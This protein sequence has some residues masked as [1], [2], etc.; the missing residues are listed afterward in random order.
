MTVMKNSFTKA[1]ALMVLLFSLSSWVSAGP[2]KIPSLRGGC[3][4]GDWSSSTDCVGL[5]NN[6]NDHGQRSIFNAPELIDK[7]GSGFTNFDPKGFQFTS[8]QGLSGTWSTAENAFA[9]FDSVLVVIK[10][11]QFA[12]AY[13]IDTSFFSGSWNISGANWLDIKRKNKGV[14]HALSHF[15]FWGRNGGG[16]NPD[17]APVPE[18]GVLGLFALG[19]FAMFFTRRKSTMLKNS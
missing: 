8:M 6:A 17:P 18:P 7:F 19:L 2:L 4:L 1:M 12:S 5:F 9:D 14:N 15:G 11:G 16:N 10:A 13:E 3:S